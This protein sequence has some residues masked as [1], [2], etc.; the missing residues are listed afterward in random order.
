MNSILCKSFNPSLE[1]LQRNEYA[2]AGEK[3]VI[4]R[5]DEI[6]ADRR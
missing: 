4:S 2:R 6:V 5:C 1:I 3:H